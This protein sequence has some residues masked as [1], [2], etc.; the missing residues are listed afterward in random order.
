MTF[1][2]K[3]KHMT[4]LN[5][6]KKNELRIRCVNVIKKKPNYL[7][8]GNREFKKSQLTAIFFSYF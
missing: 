7:F 5:Q 3:I 1:F 8:V 6:L 2:V 4:F